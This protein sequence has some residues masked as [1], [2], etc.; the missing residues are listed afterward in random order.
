MDD[1]VGDGTN[2][3]APISTSLLPVRIQGELSSPIFTVSSVHI[4]DY[5]AKRS[6]MSQCSASATRTS[7][8]RLKLT[9]PASSFW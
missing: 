7:V 2:A 5:F 3:G 8:F 1:P 9:S 4:G 6:A